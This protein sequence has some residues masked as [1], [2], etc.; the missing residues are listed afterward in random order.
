MTAPSKP[1][2]VLLHPLGVD[3]RFWRPVVEALPAGMGDVIVP[4]LLGHGAAPPPPRRA[5]IDDFA[6]AVETGIARHGRVHLVGMSLGGLVAQV[7]AARRPDLVERLVIADS[8]AVY[9]GA[10]RAM[11]RDRA[12]KVRREGIEGVVEA[13][14]ALWFSR[15]FRR[16][17]TDAVARV[18]RIL[19]SCDPEGYARTCGA[20]AVVDTTDAVRSI[21]AP[22][23]VTCGEDDAPP[24]R[25]AAQWFGET[26][27]EPTVAWLPGGHATAYEHPKRFADLVADF[28][29]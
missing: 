15:M 11:W 24:F 28:L 14:E 12:A 13:T 18:R 26:L 10:M 1:P 29:S 27:P 21:T 9:P 3:H 6:D 19:L 5:S 7:L 2:L 22:V 16:D 25:Q 17:E 4:D 20:L 8:V 23:L